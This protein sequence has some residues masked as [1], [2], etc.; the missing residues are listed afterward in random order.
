MPSREEAARFYSE[1]DESNR[2]LN[3]RFSLNS[4]SSLFNTDFSQY[5]EKCSDQWTEES[6]NNA[7]RNLLRGVRGLSTFDQNDIELIREC[8][9]KLSATD[10]DSA[11]KLNTMLDKYSTD[12]KSSVRV[13]DRL[14][15]RLKSLLR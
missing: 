9:N 2:Q 7:I 8:A 1:F 5:P 14:R 10:V 13:K 3:K 15:S 6:A 4:D 12:E 11:K